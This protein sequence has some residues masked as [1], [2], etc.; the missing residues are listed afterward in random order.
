MNVENNSEQQ[1]IRIY[2]DFEINFYTISEK[3]R[4][5]CI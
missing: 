2:M 5:Y 1:F 4:G 3:L